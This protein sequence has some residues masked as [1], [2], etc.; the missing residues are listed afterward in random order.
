[1]PASRRIGPVD[2]AA[3]HRALADELEAFEAELGAWLGAGHVVACASG[4]DALTLAL[5]AIGLRPGDEV[6]VP[7]FTIFV[8]AEVVALLGGVP[9]FAEVEPVTCA[10]DPAAVAR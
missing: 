8:D 4:T 5:L 6:I 1:M 9:R 2:L 7:A 10:I 3:Q